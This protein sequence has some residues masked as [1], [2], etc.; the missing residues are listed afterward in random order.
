M[1][2]F[3]LVLAGCGAAQ[4]PAASLDGWWT[5]DV[6]MTKQTEGHLVIRGNT[7]TIAGISAELVLDERGS[8]AERVV[9]NGWRH[10]DLGTGEVRVRG[11]EVFWLQGSG[12]VNDTT[13]AT[14]LAA[15]RDGDALVA[16]VHAL[17]DRLKLAFVITGSTAFLREHGHNLGHQFHALTVQRSGDQISFTA[18]RGV[19]AHGTVHDDRMHLELDGVDL[20][21]DLTRGAFHPARLTAPIAGDGWT[22][23]TLAAAGMDPAPIRAWIDHINTPPISAESPAIHSLLIAR[24]GV[25]VVE[26]YFV[27]DPQTPHDT[28][29]AGKSWGTTLSG[30][31]IDHQLLA[32]DTPIERDIQL[33]HALSMTTGLDC[34]DNDDNSPG[35]EDKMYGQK[36]DRDWYHYA[37]AL[38]SIRAPGERGVYCTAGINLGG[39]LVGKATHEWLPAL[40]VNQLGAPLGMRDYYLNLMP[41]EEGYLG[42]GIQMRPRDFAKLAQVF[43]DH[44]KWHGQQIVSADWVARATAAHTSINKPDDYGYGWWR[45]TLDGHAA[46]YASG[47]GGQLAIAIPDLDL[48]ISIMSGNYN[49]FNTW[50][51]FV[52]DDVPRYAIAAIRERSR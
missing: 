14:P 2:A 7:A 9:N 16:E 47:N 12:K 36:D 29:S 5:T 28:R 13:Y 39:Y 52:D 3:V 20:A 40:F 6:V 51:H 42:G 26:Q 48:V 19:I 4:T 49:D 30:I 1:R 31:A 25:L 11:D 17:P 50:K 41:S 8:A 18:K 32:L 38:N 45:T 34:D 21:V 44:G 15:R 43:L 35:N 24:H 37:L 46:F 33:Q 22:I 27:D 23:G 10:A